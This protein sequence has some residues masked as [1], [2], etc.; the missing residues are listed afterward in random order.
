MTA[1]PTKNAHTPPIVRLRPRIETAL[2]TVL[3]RYPDLAV[4]GICTNDADAY[5]GD[6]PHELAGQAR[7]AG[8]TFPYLVDADQKDGRAY[9][10]ACTPDFFLYD[11]APA[12][13]PRRVRPV[14]T[15]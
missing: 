4:A 11:S 8:W 10:V 2:G 3:S 5:P 6:Q 7:R 12:G 13:L 14:H 9:H 15:R 1:E